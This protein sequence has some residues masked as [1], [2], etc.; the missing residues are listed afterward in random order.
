MTSVNPFEVSM[1]AQV[2]FGRTDC[3]TKRT[4]DGISYKRYH[5]IFQIFQ[6]QVALTQVNIIIILSLMYT[7]NESRSLQKYESRNEIILL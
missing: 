6:M 3:A 4:P 7:S 5:Q 1:W 2:H